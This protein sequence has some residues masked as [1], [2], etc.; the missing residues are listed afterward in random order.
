[1]TVAGLYLDTAAAR[2]VRREVLEA[3]WPHLAGGEEGVFGNPSSRHEHGRRAAEAL[4]SARRVVAQHLGCRPGE[5]VFTSGGT[6]G[7]NL[8]VK[9]IA[10]GDPRRRRIVTSP[11]EHEA[12]HASIEHLVR[13]HGFEAV[14][15]PVDAEGRV[16]PAVLERA[17]TPATTLVTI[18]YANSE[19]GTVQPIAELAAV[20]HAAGVPFHTDAVQAVG[21][22][23][24]GL[25]PLGAD[26]LSMAGHKI[27]APRGIGALAIRGDVPLEPLVHG[28]GQERG[29]RSGTENVAGAV[30]LA[31]ALELAAAEREQATTAA[32]D[33]LIAGVLAGVPGA[34]L[35]G[36]RIDRLPHHASFCFPGTAGEAVLLELEARGIACSAGSACGEGGDEPP[37]AVLAIDIPHE[38]AQTAVR[39]SLPAG[40]SVEAARAVAGEIAAAVERVA[41][42]A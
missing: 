41:R 12:V 38:V 36:P 26:A 3:M 2:P 19:I 8:A 1:M 30:G 6:E 17:L 37:R 4:E 5:V 35:T 28:G 27:G 11:L 7:A 23:P 15:L 20:A 40:L 29:R 21:A 31:V 39:L 10:L 42:L 34:V 13:L 25:R 33:A 14:E 18:Q 24:V 9:G 32:R 22:L 16:D